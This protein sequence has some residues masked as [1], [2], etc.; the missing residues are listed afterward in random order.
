MVMVDDDGNNN[1]N[2]DG[3]VFYYIT[4]SHTHA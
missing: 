1:I 2:N 4:E 3:D